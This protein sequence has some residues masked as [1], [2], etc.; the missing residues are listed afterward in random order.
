MLETQK[1]IRRLCQREP[2]LEGNIRLLTTIPGVGS[3]VGAHLLAR[4]GDWRQ[5]PKAK[6]VAS[7]LGL[8]PQEHSTGDTVHKGRITG[9]G[10]HRLRSKLIQGAWM[11]I[12]HDRELGEFYHRIYLNHPKDQAAQKA[13]VAVAR[14]IAMRVG[15]VLKN[16]KPYESRFTPS[17]TVGEPCALGSSS[18]N[19]Q[20]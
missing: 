3:I 12:R 14:K 15:S 1:E 8:T 16:Q 2:E 18:D 13:I 11:A 5:I 17:Q 6:H 7:F 10:D 19:S 9:A 4:I 20:N